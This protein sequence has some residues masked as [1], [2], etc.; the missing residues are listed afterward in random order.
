MKLFVCVNVT[1]QL[2][3]HTCIGIVGGSL[4]LVSSF[5]SYDTSSG[6][7]EI[8]LNGQWG[9]VCNDLFGSTD[10]NVACRQLGYSG[11]NND[12]NVFELG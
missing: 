6:R 3:F 5:S 8:Y 12:G 7:L 10:A 9:T 1:R 2:K 11:S 4:R